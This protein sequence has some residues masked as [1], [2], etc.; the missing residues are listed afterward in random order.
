MNTT[1]NK[2]I[3]RLI[4]ITTTSLTVLSCTK[5]N[6]NEMQT[7]DELTKTTNYIGQEQSSICGI[8]PQDLAVP[9]GN[10]LLMQTYATGVQI[11]QVRRNAVDPNVFEW[12]NI[13]PSAT[14]YTRRDFTNPIALHYKGPTWEFIKG[15]DKDERVVAS[16]LKGVTVDATAIAW[17]LLKATDSLSS[18]GNRIT[19]IQRVCTNGGLPP[20]KIASESNIG[21]LDSIPYTAS[22]LFYTKD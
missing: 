16:K 1:I 10:K 20:S 13:A 21:E 15:P 14:L 5:N 9:R 11:Y 18:P 8:I 4:F 22:Y 17:L 19:F 3:Y 6:S 2:T 7:S 12:I